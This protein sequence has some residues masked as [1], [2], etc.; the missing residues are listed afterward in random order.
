MVGPE[1]ESRAQ[2]RHVSRMFVVG[3]HLTV[4]YFTVFLRRGYGL[5]AMAMA[6]GGFHESFF[7]VAW[8]TGEFGAMG[9]EGSVKS[10]FKKELEAAETPEEKKELFNKLVTKMYEIGKAIN[11]AAYMEIDSVIDPADTRMWI[12]KG[13]KSVAARNEET[14]HSFID[15]W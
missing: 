5:G 10:G 8:P 7:T 2:V 4:P 15:T 6:K 1:M 14:T 11:V 12:M 13:L 9:I 3:S